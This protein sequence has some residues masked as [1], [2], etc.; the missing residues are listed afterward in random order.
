MRHF[1]LLFIFAF[2][3]KAL[4]QENKQYIATR[5]S[6]PV[7]VD[8][9][10]DEPFW[11]NI[12]IATDFIQNKLQ[13]GA[14]SMQ[15]T[16]VKLVYDNTAVYIAATM[17]DAAPDSILT[18]MGGRDQGNTNTDIFGFA[19]DTYDDDIN[20]Y[21]FSVTAS[22]VQ[23]DLR[24][25][26]NGE[27]MDWNAV[28]E[29]KTRI[30]DK[31]W[32]AEIK[33]PYSAIRFPK[34]AVQTW[35]VNFM[36]EIRR[37]REQAFWNYVDP[38]KEG[39]VNQFG[40]LRGIENIE[41]PLRLSFT[42]YVSGYI[43]HYGK[44]E[45]A[46]VNKTFNFG[47]DVKYGINESF[48]LD[49]TLV[50]DF[51]QVQSDNVVLNLSPFEVRYNEFRPFFTEGTE[52]FN[53]GGWFYSRR[54][55]GTPLKYNDV[56]D[57]LNGDSLISNPSATQLINATKLS[58]RTA[59]GLGI[60]LFNAVT[61]P[62]YAV[63]QTPE[64]EM[65][66]ILTNPL[67]NY[68]VI[69]LDQSLKNNSY[70]SFV[71][72]NVMREG[73]FYDANLTGG[74]FNVADKTNTYAVEGSGAVSQLYSTETTLGHTYEIDAAKISGKWQYG[75]EHGVE[76]DTYDPNDLGFLYNNN[77]VYYR[78]NVSYNIFKPVWKINRLWSGLGMYYSELYK[79]R[80]FQSF[81]IFANAGTMF[82]KSFLAAGINA[83]TRPVKS[84][85]YFEPRVPGRFLAVPQALQGGGWFSSDYR[86]KLALDGYFDIHKFNE[87]GR[88]GLNYRLAPRYRASDRL[89]FIFEYYS[90]NLFNNQGWVNFSGDSI[91]IGVRD[92]K[93]ITN[94]LTAR[95]S[96]SPVMGV[97]LRV[98]HYW[99]KAD[100]K[101]FFS[102]ED[103]GYLAGS[104]Y[105]GEHDISF[106]AF[107]ID[108]VYTWNFAPGSE[109]S[110]VWKNAIYNSSSL[111]VADYYRNFVYTLESPQ[112]NSLSVKV[113][114]YL[115]YLSLKRK[116]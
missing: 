62:T 99:S 56:E 87:K 64:K 89:M 33:I 32:Y 31:G 109:M 14:P 59:G 72:T 97:S 75:L 38:A 18:E 23:I 46:A 1:F 42:P 66:K 95:Y 35:G 52:L 50:P 41:S 68:N 19:L 82:T 57:E 3:L 6:E 78:A 114:Y 71:N 83:A 93:T 16:E 73:G 76:S 101:D 90:E 96:F 4:S 17:F 106:N 84:Y 43:D 116:R 60:G 15:H 29:S 55:G 108:M 112:L 111:L 53:K 74:L 40:D 98:R 25:S 70:V 100:Y 28:W 94:T 39:F 113:L 104:N 44:K 51:G 92:I 45:N 61:S 27:D 21:A 9:Y 67:T 30:D 69:V 8:G 81:N 79:P 26:A 13:P 47:T 86:K 34:K 7:K 10:F 58:G 54:V 49:M 24:F 80:A 102:L 115:D 77:E 11:Q 85:D 103:D 105:E 20:A 107:N 36:R 12:P 91:I 5:I 37:Y 22:G 2:S 110:I 48:T 65:R 88:H 63:A